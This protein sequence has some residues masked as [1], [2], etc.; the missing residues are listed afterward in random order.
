MKWVVVSLIKTSFPAV[1]IVIPLLLGE[2]MMM[3]VIEASQK[4]RNG[5]PPGTFDPQPEATIEI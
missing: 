5:L 3:K 4:G 1:I 2:M